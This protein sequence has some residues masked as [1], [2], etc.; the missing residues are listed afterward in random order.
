VITT[1][2]LMIVR[3]S[4]FARVCTVSS[5]A[6][7]AMNDMSSMPFTGVFGRVSQLWICGLLD[8]W[9]IRRF[10]DGGGAGP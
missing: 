9:N 3:A 7:G 10:D 6:L 8:I 2:D 1:S 4:I 5:V